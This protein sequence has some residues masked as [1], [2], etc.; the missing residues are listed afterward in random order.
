MQ[1]FTIE[2]LMKKLNTG[3]KSKL[4]HIWPVKGKKGLKEKKKRFR[5][6]Y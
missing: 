4:G 2:Y 1:K 5:S 6:T 3:R